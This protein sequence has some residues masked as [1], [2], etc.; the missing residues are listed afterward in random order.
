MN[1]GGTQMSRTFRQRSFMSGLLIAAMGIA[2]P[3]CDGGSNYD[4]TV[5]PPGDGEPVTDQPAADPPVDMTISPERETT[6]ANATESDF[7]VPPNI[8]SDA[9]AQQQTETEPDFSLP[10]DLNQPEN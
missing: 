2:L 8:D 5:K 3:G 1:A 6:S 10:P 4:Q 7:Q 9:P